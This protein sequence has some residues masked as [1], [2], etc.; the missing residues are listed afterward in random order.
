[1]DLNEE[2]TENIRGELEARLDIF[3][4]MHQKK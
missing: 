3:R 4:K 1:M 2:M